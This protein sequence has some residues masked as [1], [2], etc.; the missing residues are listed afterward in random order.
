MM[1]YQIPMFLPLVVPFA[2]VR[3]GFTVNF[4]QLTH[5]IDIL[6]DAWSPVSLRI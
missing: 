4:L 6:K 1:A 5:H 3:P 2:S